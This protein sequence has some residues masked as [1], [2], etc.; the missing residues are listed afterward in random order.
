M[1]SAPGTDLFAQ[2]LLYDTVRTGLANTPQLNGNISGQTWRDT[3]KNERAAY[4][5]GYDALSRLTSSTYGVLSGTTL[6][7]T[8]RYNENLTYDLNGNIKTLGRWGLSGTTALQ[9]DNLTYGYR[10]NRLFNVR[11]IS[12]TTL[13]FQETSTSTTAQE[14]TFDAMGNLVSD[15]NPTTDVYLS[16]NHLNRITERRTTAGGAVQATYTWAADGTKLKAQNHTSGFTTDYIGPYQYENGNLAFFFT[17]EGRCIKSGAS[18][19]YEYVIKDHLGNTRATFDVPTGT[20]ARLVQSTHYYPFGLEINSLAYTLSP[21][22]PNDYKYNGKELQVDFGLPYYDYG[23]RMYDPQLGRWHSVDP[24]AEK[25]LSISPFAYALNNPV[26]FTDPTGM[27]VE[28]PILTLRA[29]TFAPFNY[30]GAGAAAGIAKFEGDGENRR[31]STSKAAK[32]KTSA[33]VNLHFTEN[34]KIKTD[35]IKEGQSLSKGF[36]NISSNPRW[37]TTGISETTADV[38][39]ND[40]GNTIQLHTEGNNDAMLWGATPD[41]DLTVTATFSVLENEDGSGQLGVVAAI[42]GDRF[43]SAES[44]L[45]DGAGN[46]IFIGVYATDGS[47]NTGVFRLVGNYNEPQSLQNFTVNY[48]SSGAFTSV[49]QGNVTYTIEEWNKRFENQ[50]TKK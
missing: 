29:S 8:N 41:I 34:G 38:S 4:R 32:Y 19:V 50:P 24:L 21:G 7:Q 9:I 2:E 39:I 12:S 27:A 23:A 37:T 13:G 17:A 33:E 15:I 44:T 20:T 43:P 1:P 28:P 16:Y 36:D 35:K 22:A 47:R 40:K 11:D 45:T 48:N 26:I 6:T 30:F 14:Y 10:G 31:F 49:V 5:Y 42:N 3:Y 18:Y 25:Y 46:S